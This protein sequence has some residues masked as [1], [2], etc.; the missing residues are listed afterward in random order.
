MIICI[1]NDISEEQL[2]DDIKHHRELSSGNACC[3]YYIIDYLENLND[4]DVADY[5]KQLKQSEE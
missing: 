1:C 3:R 2:L 4:L 5:I